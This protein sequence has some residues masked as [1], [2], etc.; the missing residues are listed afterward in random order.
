MPPNGD[1]PSAA[2]T[3]HVHAGKDL[4]V[5][6]TR[7]RVGFKLTQTASNTP[8]PRT[9]LASQPVLLTGE[10]AWDQ[11]EQEQEEDEL[12]AEYIRQ[13]QAQVCCA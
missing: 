6:S 11:A 2:A 5:V 1:T 9:S 7:T 3:R 10:A 8:V 12:E 4:R 13:T